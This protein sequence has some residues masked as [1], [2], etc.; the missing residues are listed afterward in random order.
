MTNRIFAILMLCALSPFGLTAQDHLPAE[1]RYAMPLRLPLSLSANFGELRP[2]H[3]HSGV[4]AKTG[5][6]T[7]ANR[8]T[9]WLTDTCRA[10]S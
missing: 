2:N 3:F 1:G 7:G 4:D 5:G 9:R 8:S 6:V 10:Y